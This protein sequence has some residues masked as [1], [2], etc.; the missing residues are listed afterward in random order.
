MAGCGGGEMKAG[1]VTADTEQLGV[2]SKSHQ[3]Q[4]VQMRIP[5]EGG[6]VSVQ[7]R[8]THKENI[9]TRASAA[10]KWALPVER[11]PARRPARPFDHSRITIRV[12]MQKA[13]IGE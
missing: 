4:K 6:G 8:A 5:G 7:A 11:R 1:G 12:L 10:Q 13:V 3:D 9:Y 2:W